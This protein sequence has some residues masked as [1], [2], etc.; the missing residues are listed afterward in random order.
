VSRAG[1][2]APAKWSGTSAMHF[3]APREPITSLP[4]LPKLN[5][6]QPQTLAFQ[7]V[8]G[9]DRR[10]VLRLWRTQ[11]SIA[12]SDEAPSMP[13]WLGA[14]EAERVVRRRSVLSIADE[15][16]DPRAAVDELAAASGR[17]RI[18]IRAS[19]GRSPVVLIYPWR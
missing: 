15:D 19:P 8:D 12:L 5:E 18:A 6:G 2:N 13:L 11:Y 1:W 7:K 14:L 4:V 3:L 9:A 16:V 17:I 10:L